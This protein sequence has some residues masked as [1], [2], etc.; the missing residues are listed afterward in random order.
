MKRATAKSG[1]SRDKMVRAAGAAFREHGLGGI[2]VDGLAKAAD[3]TS[4]AFYFHFPSK[5]DAFVESVRAGLEDLKCGI[6]GIQAAEG[7]GW[8]GSFASFYM[9]FKRTCRLGEGCALPLLSAEV[10]R[11]GDAARGVYQEKLT[12]VIGAVE[13]GLADR[14]GMSAR[15]QA[16]VIL[17]L[18]AGGATMG[19]TVKDPIL[20][21]EIG[22]AVRRAVERV[23]AG[24]ISV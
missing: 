5:M 12:E 23:G 10:E 20:S 11:A 8:L 19:R 13:R 7:K 6:E 9:G 24:S 4:G 14:E 1:A 22:E 18:L 16:L 21:A 17:A 15:E 3:F 2:G